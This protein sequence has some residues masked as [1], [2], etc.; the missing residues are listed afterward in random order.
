MAGFKPQNIAARANKVGST[1]NAT[2]NRLAADI[3][4]SSNISVDGIASAVEGTAAE[5]AS[6]ITNPLNNLA[7]QF[8][9]ALG[10]IS[11]GLGGLL[12][13]ILGGFPPWPNELEQ[14]ASYNY[15]FGLHCLTNDEINNPDVT[16]RIFEPPITILKSG[17]SGYKKIRTL[18][19]TRGATEFYID[20]VRIESIITP[21]NKTK[22]SNAT[23][24]TFEVTEPH[25]MGMFLQTLQMAA[26]TAGHKNYLEAPFLLTIEFKGYDSNGNAMAS[27]NSRRLIPLNLTN[28]TF[29]V[30][31][32]GSVYSV[33]AVPWAE[34][35]MS[36][37]V[38]SVK[39]DV[40][41]TGENV[42]ELLQGPGGLAS[43]L[44]DRLLRTQEAGQISKADQY[45]F[46]F[47]TKDSSLEE[48]LTGSKEGDAGATSKEGE[49]KEFTE[50]E[51]LE[52]YESLT[53]ISNGKLPVDFDQK[54]QELLG[55]VI[56]RSQLGETIRDYAENEEN[57]NDIGKAEI[58]KSYLEG[59][60]VPFGEAKF[61][62]VEGKPG[63]FQRG[64]VQISDK[65]KTLS[66]PKSSRIQ[67]IIEEVILLSDY[68]RQIATAEPDQ[69][70]M[71]PW[72]KIEPQMYNVTDTETSD[73]TGRSPRIYVYRVV[74]YMVSQSRFASPTKP[75]PKQ[76]LAKVQAAK[77]YNYIYTG[78]NKDILEF[79]I[80]IDSAFFVALNPMRAQAS[81]SQKQGGKTAIAEAEKETVKKL[82]EG[83]TQTTSASGSKK[84]EEG[85]KP[86]SGT[87]SGGTEHAETQV[88][89][90]VNEAIL[91]SPSDLVNVQMKIWGD[92]FYL[93]DS[94]MG[95]YN[96]GSTG[97][98]NLNRNGT[99][100]YQSSEVDVTLNF[101][102][103]IDYKGDGWMEFPGGGFAP[104]A[105]FSGLYQVVLVVHSFSKG[106]FTQELD[107]IRRPL[108]DTETTVQ[109]VP[110]G[111][112]IMVDGAEENKI[113]QVEG[114]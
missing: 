81:A 82:N 103:P 50:D 95:N 49:L 75:S 52:I 39:T 62:E 111:N 107:M 96:A 53:G 21:N 97:F 22:Q 108:Q 109:A 32:G 67:D 55:V 102:T 4:N 83:D 104:V 69:N 76:A 33:E 9:S 65:G 35:A 44:N 100:N 20:D 38:Q 73:Q 77:E 2:A 89:R 113:D 92:P 25:S 112:A 13:G 54:I 28:A 24:V 114:T 16:Y 80:Q 58:V 23:L 3:K 48:G 40:S 41:I 84:V 31:E 87:H 56:T 46:V 6:A 93:S 74:P 64:K 68:G 94:G 91:N 106:M 14:F 27:R 66:F 59:G 1:I 57:I 10:Q 85:D 18:Y 88:A 17:G 37:Q 98:I 7:S 19:E 43:V 51:K 71:V 15:I 42:Q 72:F 101:K 105:A 45:V 90:D 60:A 47:P 70:N 11:G 30:T 79:D 5:L 78:K 12:G 29:N 63:T 61:S 34:K 99:M 36:D 8:S 86:K 26:L 110:G